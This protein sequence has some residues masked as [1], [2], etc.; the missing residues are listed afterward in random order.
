MLPADRVTVC[1]FA[2]SAF[3]DVYNTNYKAYLFFG[4]PCVF[5]AGVEEL[6]KMVPRRTMRFSVALLQN[7]VEMV[8]LFPKWQL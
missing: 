1:A 8:R 2:I 7:Y 6:P 5:I 3:P 4:F